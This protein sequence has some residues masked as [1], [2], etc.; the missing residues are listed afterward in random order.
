MALARY[1]NRRDANEPIIFAFLRAQGMSVCP[2]DTPADA[3]VGFKG[4]TYLVE[5]KDGPK[6]KLTPPQVKFS[7][8]WRGCYT[9]LHSIEEAETWV[10]EIKLRKERA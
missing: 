10:K 5:I 2:L 7:S 1:N 8:T 6:K 4:R 3:L 9:V